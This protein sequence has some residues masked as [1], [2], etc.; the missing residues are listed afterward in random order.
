MGTAC[1]TSE[2]LDILKR[3]RRPNMHSHMCEKEIYLQIFNRHWEQ[4]QLNPRGNLEPEAFDEFIQRV[5]RD[6]ISYRVSK[7][8][9]IKHF[10]YMGVEKTREIGKK[11]AQRLIEALVKKRQLL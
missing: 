11:D 8:D 5:V 3:N 1:C 2:N 4:Q 6:V 9:I 7:T 10:Q